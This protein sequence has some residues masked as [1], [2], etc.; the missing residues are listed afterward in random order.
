MHLLSY[1][2]RK[3][4]TLRS[5]S[6]RPMPPASHDAMALCLGLAADGK[7]VACRLGGGCNVYVHQDD[8]LGRQMR[9]PQGAQTALE[10]RRCGGCLAGRNPLGSRPSWGEHQNRRSE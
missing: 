1:A 7:Q 5:L 4:F 3:Q 10:R 9:R 6:C 2:E 8:P